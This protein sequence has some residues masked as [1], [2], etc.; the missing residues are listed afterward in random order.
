MLYRHNRTGVLYRT[1]FNAFDVERQCPSI[2]YVQV[3]TGA[4]FVREEKDFEE[5]FT[6]VGDAQAEIVPKDKNQTEMAFDADKAN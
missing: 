1:L 5:K 3:S 2:V 4:I 6:F